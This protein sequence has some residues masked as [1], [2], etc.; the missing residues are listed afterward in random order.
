MWMREVIINTA[1]ETYDK[2][3]T[4]NKIKYLRKEEK[5][6]LDILIKNK[7]EM[8]QSDLVKISNMPPYKITRILNTFEN[9]EIIKREKLGVTNVIHLIIEIE[10][11]VYN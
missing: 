2:K 10:N 5:N 8:V 4:A 9:L 6:I 11:A 3:F 1:T 7:P